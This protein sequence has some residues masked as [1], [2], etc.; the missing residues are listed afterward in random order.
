MA[1]MAAVLLRPETGYG[2][3][4]NA[5]KVDGFDA[6]LTPTANTILPLDGNLRLPNSVL[7]TGS[8]NGLNA[9]IV[10]DLHAS[11]IPNAGQLL[12]LD[13]NAKFPNSVLYTGSGNGLDADMVDGLHAS[14]FIQLGQTD[15]ITGVMLIDGSVGT[16]E[17][18]DNSIT[19]AK[20][21][22]VTRTITANLMGWSSEFYAQMAAGFG[23]RTMSD[24]NTSAI[25]SFV[26]PYDYAG[27][28]LTVREWWR[29][30]DYFGTAN[31][32]LASYRMTPSGG[33]G[34]IDYQYFNYTVNPPQD[35]ENQRTRIIPESN[36]FGPGD[37]IWTQYERQGSSPEDTMGR[38][39]LRAVAVEYT[40]EQ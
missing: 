20:I 12:A 36:L 1:L 10:D 34:G 28:D 39:D 21:Q 35:A 13:A 2:V 38:L 27:G 4:V 11:S 7:N 22:N 30:G 26:V 24:G 37:I 18:S 5:D 33:G 6:S 15:S 31:L 25:Y 8:G 32:L 17:I 23:V 14:A 3:G 16:A 40:A 19:G 9:D 29:V